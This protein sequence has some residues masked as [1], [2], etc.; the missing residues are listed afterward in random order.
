[1]SDPLSLLTQQRRKTRAPPD[2]KFIG[3][4]DTVKAFDDDYVYDISLVNSAK[5]FR[6]ALAMNEQRTAFKPEIWT[7]NKVDASGQKIVPPESFLQGWFL[8][9]HAD[10]GGANQHD[11]LSLYPLQ[12]MLCEACDK[13]LVLGSDWTYNINDI[14]Q[15]MAEV[16]FPR[17]IQNATGNI[18]AR[19]TQEAFL[20]SNGTEI[21]MWD[22]RSMHSERRYRIRLNTEIGI[23]YL[24]TLMP[25][26]LF[27]EGQLLGYRSQGSL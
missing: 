20:L 22:I 12:W 6:Q 4:L 9:T 11:G 10:I 17:G 24:Y 23:R 14:I 15:N 16:L 7:L 5:H 1:M 19:H 3:A 26:K 2:I 25:R 18:S 21:K 27:D 13:G 8:G